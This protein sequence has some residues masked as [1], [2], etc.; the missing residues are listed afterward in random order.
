VLPDTAFRLAY[1][2]IEVG[3]TAVDPDNIE[4]TRTSAGA[5]LGEVSQAELDAVE[6]EAVAAQ[7]TADAAGALAAT[8]HPLMQRQDITD[9]TAS[10]ADGVSVERNITVAKSFR[11][12]KLAT[13]RAARV[14]LYGTDADRDA[15]LSRAIG[16]DPDRRS[17]C[18]IG[19]RDDSW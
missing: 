15:D 17:W 4:D 1:V 18:A 3:D 14:R 9:T 16:T 19:L 6:A 10:I 7:A 13:S 8:K 2:L 5:N 11:L 12:L